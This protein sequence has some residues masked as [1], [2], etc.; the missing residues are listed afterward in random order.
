LEYFHESIFKLTAFVS[1]YKQYKLQLE[2][3]VSLN[4]YHFIVYFVGSDMWRWQS[5]NP[6]GYTS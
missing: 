1:L 3:L 6:K 2:V 4:F 5:M